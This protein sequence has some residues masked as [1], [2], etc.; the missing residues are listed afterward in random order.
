MDYKYK[1]LLY[2]LKHGRE[3]EFKFNNINYSI[4]Y[5]KEYWYF[6]NDLLGNSIEISAFNNKAELLEFVNKLFI[7][8]MELKEIFNKLLYSELYIF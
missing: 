4:T 5:N 2:D 8:N 7:D 6:Y 3:I 1:D